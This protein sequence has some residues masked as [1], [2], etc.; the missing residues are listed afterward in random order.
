[1]KLTDFKFEVDDLNVPEEPVEPRDAAK[2]MV[3]NREDESIKH[4]TFADLHKYV[5]EG[6]VI[7][8]NNTKVFPARLRGK[9]K[10]RKQI[11]KSFCLE[12]C[13]LKICFG[14][15]WLSRQEKSGLEINSTL[16]KI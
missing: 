7:I 4:E 12:N 5:N 14:M 13:S 6:D 3:L 2:L 15:F 16:G 10:K 1:M 9:K 8:Y 11:S